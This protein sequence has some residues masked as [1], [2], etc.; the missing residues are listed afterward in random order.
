MILEKFPGLNELSAAEKPQ[1]AGELWDDL[2]KHPEDFPKRE[3]RV[4]GSLFRK[5]SR[6]RFHTLRRIYTP[7]FQGYLERH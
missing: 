6:V 2:E 1:L 4:K 5:Y 3:D 7:L